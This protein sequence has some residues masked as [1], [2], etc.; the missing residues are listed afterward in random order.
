MSC[1]FCYILIAGCQ[2]RNIFASVIRESA[3][4]D[5]MLS[6]CPS[7]RLSVVRCPFNTFRVTRYL[8]TDFYRTAVNAGRSSQGKVSVRPSVCPPVKPMNCD[9]PEEKSVQ[10]FTPY[11]R[12]FDLVFWEKEWLVVA[13][14]STRNFGSTGPRWR[15][16]ANFEPIFARSASAVRPSEKV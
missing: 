9:K 14:P 1:K 16:I 6:G 7:V 4:G 5:I 13:T 3:A 8:R 2:L 12:S 10:I 11:E 15:E